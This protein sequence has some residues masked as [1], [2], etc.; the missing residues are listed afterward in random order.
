MSFASVGPLQATNLDSLKPTL[1]DS[2]E[3]ACAAEFDVNL[4]FALMPVFFEECTRSYKSFHNE[5]SRGQPLSPLAPP[6]LSRLPAGIQKERKG[7]MSNRFYTCFEAGVQ[8]SAP[9]WSGGAG[10]HDA[11]KGSKSRCYRFADHLECRLSSRSLS[12]RLSIVLQTLRFP[13]LWMV[14]RRSFQLSDDRQDNLD[15]VWQP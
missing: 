3:L 9:F 4:L 6:S 14:P 5:H 15:V 7:F 13:R 12:G 10:F 1:P 8:C 2:V 11:G